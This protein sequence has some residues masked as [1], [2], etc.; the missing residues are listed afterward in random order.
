MHSVNTISNQ[1]LDFIPQSQFK[2]LVDQYQFD[3][4]GVIPYFKNVIFY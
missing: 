4:D 2:R 3:F 1:L